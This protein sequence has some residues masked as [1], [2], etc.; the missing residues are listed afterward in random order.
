MSD[1]PLILYQYRHLA[2]SVVGSLSGAVRLTNSR[3]TLRYNKAM[4]TLKGFLRRHRFITGVTAIYALIGIVLLAWYRYPLNPDGISYLSIARKYAAGDF[5]HAVNGYWS[6]FLSWAL[7]PFAFAGLNLQVAS[8]LILLVGGVVSLPLLWWLAGAWGSSNGLRKLLVVTAVPLLWFWILAGPITPDALVIPVVL[9]YAALLTIRRQGWLWGGSLGV[10]VALGYYIKSYLLLFFIL[11]I[12]VYIVLTAILPV[13]REIRRSL[14]PA[15]EPYVWAAVAAFVLIVPWV[16]VLTAKYDGPTVSTSGSYNWSVTNPLKPGHPMHSAGL[17]APPNPTAVS[18]WEDPT[19]LPSAGWSPFDGWASFRGYSRIIADNIKRSGAAFQEF[20][21]I[22]MALAI[23]V[24]IGIVRDRAGNKRA[25]RFKDVP[26]LPSFITV[27]V[28]AAYIAGYALILVE[29]RYLWPLCLLLL[30]A[31]A[32]LASRPSRRRL[33]GRQ[34]LALVAAVIVTVV[35]SPLLQLYYQRDD[36]LPVRYQALQMAPYVPPGSRVAADDFS[37]IMHC[38]YWQA[39]C[40]GAL[41]PTS[42]DD[43]NRA[44]LKEY[45]IDAILITKAPDGWQ[46]PAYLDGFAE[47]KRVGTALLLTR[48]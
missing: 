16:A 26:G 46:K 39:A 43:K 42:G 10:L 38:Y 40:Y 9:A 36:F 12:S 27:T 18:A 11:H 13:R 34:Y 21:I 2:S 20:S 30:C 3:K 6:P 25:E 1:I 23:I 47:T 8:K 22:G 17:L 33:D 24:G 48:D 41:N 35:T 31:V 4:Q 7:A 32:A 15:I 19:Y 29:P 5:N 44:Q 28:A 14:W 37:A 45:A